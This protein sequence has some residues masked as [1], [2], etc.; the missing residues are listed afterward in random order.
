MLE[1]EPAAKVASALAAYLVD[2]RRTRELPALIRD[3][4]QLRF[5][6]DG[7]LEATAV[8]ARELTAAT[9]QAIQALL[10][11]SK[12]QLYTE[13]KPELVGGVQVRALDQQLDLTIRSKLQRLKN[14]TTKAA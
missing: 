3:L 11:A 12:V 6:R 5:A 9:R 8:S 7:V 10:P 2:E 13:I 14:L 1:R 4:E